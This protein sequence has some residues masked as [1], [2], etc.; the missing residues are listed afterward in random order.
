MYMGSACTVRIS[1][2]VPAPFR[3][4]SAYVFLNR[5]FNRDFEGPAKASGLRRVNSCLTVRGISN[6]R[7]MG[8]QTGQRSSDTDLKNVKIQFIVTTRTTS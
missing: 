3:R 1:H 7:L 4:A 6:H 8:S 5:Q 2:A